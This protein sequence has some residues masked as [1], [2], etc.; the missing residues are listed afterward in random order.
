MP[1]ATIS[2]PIAA[3]ASN[4]ILT[5]ILSLPTVIA[6][7]LL[8]PTIWICRLRVA[9]PDTWWH[10]KAGQEIGD[11]HSLPRIDHWSFTAAGH[12]WLPHEWLS[13]LALYAIFKNFGDLGLQL[14]L[15]LLAGAIVAISYAVCYRY[16]GN[17]RAAAIG[18]FMTLFFGTVG[19]TIRPHL[20]GY[21]FLSIELLLILNNRLW[22]LPPLFLIWVN[23]HASYPVGLA[24]LALTV[25]AKLD[26]RTSVRAALQRR[27]GEIACFLACLAALL[28]NPQGWRLILYPFDTLFRQKDNLGFVTEWFPLTLQDPRGLAL[29]LIV[30]ALGV[31]ALTGRARASWFELSILCPVT[32]LALQHTRM[33][34]LFGILAAPIVSRIA[35]DLIPRKP[36]KDHLPTN[37]FV[38]LMTALLTALA[39]PT[40]AQLRQKIESAEPAK[41]VDFIRSAHLTG[42][43]LNEYNFGGYLIWT[44]PDHPV[45]IDGRAD[46]YD[47]SGVL[48]QYRDWFL[49]REPP[50]KLLDEY[51]IAFCILDTSSAPAHAMSALPHWRKAY[52]D[53]VATIFIRD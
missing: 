1:A 17:A 29:A 8:C 51:K 27:R 39:I 53:Q 23:C 36:H 21:L 41:A 25:L 16:C 45:F 4:A 15:F 12:A 49:L 47:W 34:F 22:L 3:P 50:T 2:T 11:T 43:M 5:K 14:W 37:A 13:Q 24:I 32:F 46:L 7:L 18:G 42:P 38:L 30:A 35:A 9:D 40:P 28:L 33:V 44:L 10:L 19:F 48:P 52:S 26:R 31:A 20:I 6:A